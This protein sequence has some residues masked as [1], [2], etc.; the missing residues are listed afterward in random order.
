M[1]P[2]PHGVTNR[3]PMPH[4]RTNSLPVWLELILSWF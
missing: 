1:R 2:T 3:V 4:P